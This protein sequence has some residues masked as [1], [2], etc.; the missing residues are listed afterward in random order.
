[1]LIAKFCGELL[2]NTQLEIED[3]VR[4]SLTELRA[5]AKKFKLLGGLSGLARLDGR[6]KVRSARYQADTFQFHRYEDKMTQLSQSN[7]NHTLDMH[8]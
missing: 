7:E 6:D 5:L 1:M 3:S 4:H 2:R 8:R